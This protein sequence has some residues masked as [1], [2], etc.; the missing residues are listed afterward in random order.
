MNETLG[1]FGM[2]QQSDWVIR[3]V[4]LFLLIMSISSWLVIIIKLASIWHLNRQAQVVERF[5]HGTDF[6]VAL[7]YLGETNSPWRV[8]AV[9]GQEG[10]CHHKNSQP[11]LQD[12]LDLSDWITRILRNTLD[13]ISARLSAG[14]VV[15]ASIGSTAPFVGLFGTVWGIYHALMNLSG[16]G[17]S[18]IDK[19]A[20][21]I[22][23]ALLMTAFGLAVAIP[24]VLGYNVLTRANKALNHKLNRFA[25]DLHAL[26]IT[27][28]RLHSAESA[29]NTMSL[30]P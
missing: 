20:A 10:L 3:S 7:S 27:G 1:L 12:T 6:D 8:L 11:K 18:S 19:V 24:A 17:I 13:N 4:A 14:L 9:Q 30:K 2:W 21:P 22:G 16:S 5:W 26:F 23:E 25:H 28:A 15:L 29:N